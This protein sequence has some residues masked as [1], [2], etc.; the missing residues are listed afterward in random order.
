MHRAYPGQKTNISWV[1]QSDQP[2]INIDPVED[3]ENGKNEE[4]DE[5]KIEPPKTLKKDVTLGLKRKIARVSDGLEPLPLRH[6]QITEDEF[7]LNK[8]QNINW[9]K[10]I[11]TLIS[12][13][14]EDIQYE[15]IRGVDKRN[16]ANRTIKEL[17]RCKREYNLAFISVGK[18]LME[19]LRNMHPEDLRKIEED[20]KRVVYYEGNLLNIS[21]STYVLNLVNRYFFETGSFPTETSFVY[22][23]EGFTPLF[24]KSNAKIS[25]RAL[26]EKF[27]RATP[28]G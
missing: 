16:I 21:N 3:N 5:V 1:A 14:N 28:M 4:K 18:H 26:H 15:E 20:L 11:E 17:N 10:F 27:N 19:T 8:L 22:V 7:A 9:P 6:S 23:V 2:E 13:S 12:Y 24:I 25:P